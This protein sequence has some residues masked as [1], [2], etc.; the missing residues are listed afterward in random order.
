MTT[1]LLS[2][3][4][5][6]CAELSAVALPCLPGKR[7]CNGRRRPWGWDFNGASNLEELNE[8]LK[9]GFLIRRLKAREAALPRPARPGLP[10]AGSRRPLLR[11]PAFRKNP[12]VGGPHGAPEQAPRVRAPR[13]AAGGG[14]QDGGGGGG[15]AR[16]L[17]AGDVARGALQARGRA[18]RRHRP[19][20]ARSG[21][22]PGPACVLL[23]GNAE[24]R[25]R[26]KCI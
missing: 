16:A 25:R 2:L 10:L 21:P 15:A 24:M 13:A 20:G 9:Q 19:G 18:L 11:E 14:G 1:L 8:R 6:A 3:C 4:G 12:A 7:Y 17:P 23:R 5:G 26:A 22:T